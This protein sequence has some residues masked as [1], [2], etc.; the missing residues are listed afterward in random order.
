MTPVGL[1]PRQR[2][3][4]TF[5][6]HQL[7]TTNVS[8]TF[9]QMRLHLNVGSKATVF[10]LVEALEDRGH[11]VR[12]PNCRQ[13]IALRASLPAFAPQ[14]RKEDRERGLTVRLKP[15]LTE[16][17]RAYCRERRVDPASVIDAAL[18]MH[19]GGSQS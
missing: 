17:L 8:P 16:R 7:E 19:I 14:D 18:F 5:I 12:A 11:I 2:E 9:E 13:S 4:L 3:L 15:Y 10:R 6:E 1:T